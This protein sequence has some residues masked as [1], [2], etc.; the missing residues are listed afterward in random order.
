[1]VVD[2]KS[3]DRM[4]NS[5]GG[6]QVARTRKRKGI[7]PITTKLQYVVLDFGMVSFIDVTGVLSL[8]ELKMELRRYVGKELQFRFVN[9]DKPVRE[10]FDRSEWIFANCGEERTAEADV[11]YP[12]L[13]LALLHRDGD[14]KSFMNE[15]AM[16]V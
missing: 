10:R 12:T 16:E 3:A 7:T 15:K 2:R 11:V 5:Y 8:I 6:G 4:W 13:D 14:E 9:M 1:M